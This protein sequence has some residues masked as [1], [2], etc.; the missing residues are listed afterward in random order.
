MSLLIKH[1][2]RFGE[3]TVD[4]EQ[5]VLLRAGTPVALTPKVFDTLLVLI[6]NSGRIVE[7]NELMNRLWPDSFVEEANLAY[8]IQQL[9]KCLGDNARQPAYIETV[10]RRGYR[11]IAHVE[12]VLTE[13]QQT[14]GNG[15]GLYGDSVAKAPSDVTAPVTDTP[16]ANP[17]PVN[18][19]AKTPFV[20]SATASMSRRLADRT[21]FAVALFAL[22]AAGIFLYER[23]LARS[24]KGLTT[25]AKTGASRLAMP[26]AIEKLTA[27]GQSTLVA[28]SRDGRY[29]AYTIG[30]TTQAIWLRQL[31]TNTNLEILPAA[32]VVYGLA[33]AGNGEYLYFVKGDFP[34]GTSAQTC[35][36][37]LYR[38]ALVGG[39]PTRILD[40]LEGNF[41]LSADDSQIAF[42][43]ED[44]NH[45]GEREFSLMIANSDGS[46]ERTLLVGTHPNRL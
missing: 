38:V 28:I 39:V 9:R 12:D 29:I 13:G 42:I 33:F 19:S 21:A 8:N 24:N 46:G 4:T 14:G 34:E 26:V 16:A 3:F 10:A 36:K 43:R 5:K 30:T 2:F 15:T 20:N 41:S 32:G 44:I 22:L 40:N 23:S 37:V 17:V 31:S 45:D 27:A 35:P 25:N 7:K 11:F 6:E 18:E 1:F